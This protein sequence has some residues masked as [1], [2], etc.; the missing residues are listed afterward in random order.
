MTASNP[1]TTLRCSADFQACCIAGFKTCEPSA[2]R[3]RQ[4]L[5]RPADLEI[6]DTAGL[7]TCATT[8]APTTTH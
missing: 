1:I 2:N 8:P 4:I 5:R 7:E 6:G 3:P